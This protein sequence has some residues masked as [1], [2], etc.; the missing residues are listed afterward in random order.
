MPAD[1]C[2]ASGRGFLAYHDFLGGVLRVNFHG[3]QG[4]P[5]GSAPGHLVT[6]LCPYSSA[7]DPGWGF[8]CDYLVEKP[9]AATQE[10]E[11]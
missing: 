6:F 2:L 5:L 9:S 7:S 4:A 3:S 10:M 11:M 8:C 1:P